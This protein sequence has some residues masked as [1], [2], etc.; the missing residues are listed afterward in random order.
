MNILFIEPFYAGSH[1]TW[2]DQLSQYST[3]NIDL[4]TMDGKF[5]KWRMHGASITMASKLTQI[6][7][8]PD[9]IIV[10]D[11]IDLA[12]FIALSRN[13]LTM[14]GNPKIGIYF[15]ENQL[16]YPL[17]ESSK[18][19]AVNKNVHYGMINYTSALSADF[20]MFN[21]CYNRDSFLDELSLILN[22]MPDYSHTKTIDLSN[23]IDSIFKKT[24]ILPI[25]FETPVFLSPSK[26]NKM[27][28]K[29]SNIHRKKPMILWNHRLEY[30]KNPVIFF[31]TLIRLKKAN[32]N[33]QLALLGGLSQR[34]RK[35]YKYYLDQLE[36]E[37]VI[38]DYLPYEDYL[39]F[40]NIADILPVTS[41]HDFFGISVMEGI[42]YNC[43]PLLPNRLTYPA[44]YNITDNPDIFY[45]SDD[46]LYTKLAALITHSTN[47]N[48][49]TYS[50]LTKFYQWETLIIK[51]D[52]YFDQ[53]NSI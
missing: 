29:Y 23:T 10:S 51:Y 15:H 9:L 8:T 27:Y 11:M 38:Q 20:V 19:V 49:K 28:S 47:K 31:K 14:M 53:I 12:A 44:L 24:H 16:S 41:N 21:S 3:H 52:Q 30:D 25:G 40:L 39:F 5:W 36:D 6:K 33:Y 43:T 2:L 45:H 37:I 1:K 48:L 46:E 32:Y 13:T 35:K 17:P 34:N 18:D 4:L 50:Q 26:L 7:D 42:A 22:N